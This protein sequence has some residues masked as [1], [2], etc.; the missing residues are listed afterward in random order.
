MKQKFREGVFHRCI[1]AIALVF[2][3]IKHISRKCLLRLSSLVYFFRAIGLESCNTLARALSTPWDASEPRKPVLQKS[4]G[5]AFSRC[6]IHLLPVSVF[7]FLLWINYWGYYIGT[8]FSYHSRSDNRYLALYQVAAKLQEVL[9]VASLTTVV[10]QVLRHDLLYGDGVPIGLLGSGISFSSISYF[11]SPE[12]IIAAKYCLSSW[13]RCRLYF[14]IIIAGLLAVTIGPASAIL[15]L[16]RS[17]TVTVGRTQYYLNGT[18]DDFW[19]STVTSI[20]EGAICSSLDATQYAVCPSGGYFSMRSNF[21]RF[22]Y[23]N[24]G[25]YDRNGGYSPKL[26]DAGGLPPPEIEILTQSPR[27]LLPAM[28]SDM[29]ESGTSP[30]TWVTQPH[31]AT[32][33]VQQWLDGEWYAAVSNFSTQ[34]AFS[35]LAN[36]NYA[37]HLVSTTSTTIPLVRVRCS[38]PAT[39]I[40]Q[41]TERIAFPWLNKDIEWVSGNRKVKISSLNR[42]A[43]PFL[44][45][46]W[47]PLPTE[48]FG[49]ISTGLLVELPSTGD[50]RVAFGCSISAVWTQGNLVSDSD[51]SQYAWVG[52]L[53]TDAKQELVTNLSAILLNAKQTNRLIMLEP[54][55]L[56]TL[57]PSAPDVAD[58]NSWSPTTLERIITDTRIT[59]IFDDY[60]TRPQP[61]YSVIDDQCRLAA[62]PENWTETDMWNDRTCGKGNKTPL[63]ETAIAVTVA[64]GLSRFASSR[65]YNIGP[66]IQDW[67]LQ[68]SVTMDVNRDAL[69]HG[70]QAVRL[71]P[72]SDHNYIIQ[73]MTLT[74]DGY[75]Y[76]ASDIF[77]YLSTAVVAVYILVAALHTLWILHHQVTLSSWDTVTELIAL[78]INSPPTR[79]L[80]NTSAGIQRYTTYTKR[81]KIQAVRL[82]NGTDE[83]RLCFLHSDDDLESQ[84][85]NCHE[86]PPTKGATMTLA[87]VTL[88]PPFIS[89]SQSTNADPTIKITQ[90]R[91]SNLDDPIY[92][93]VQIDKKYN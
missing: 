44:R 13:K 45:L 38:F 87:E 24:L 15:L 62:T 26:K 71:P 49:N 36:Y 74:I 58:N 89:A 31:A 43:S 30:E 35:S 4:F 68:A 83:R 78:F 51:Y 29:R 81:L 53:V 66:D 32:I 86:N 57:T 19:P 23:T 90:V 82:E 56:A 88:Y 76:V 63:I 28:I 46:Q 73:E 54:S 6:I 9:C 33:A 59:K 16:P 40:T 92:E 18:A 80:D 79:A 61:Y 75:A 20:N 70:K 25:Y 8:G 50:S 1:R 55:W 69:L 48:S 72:P 5:I 47:L 2:L 10:L 39:N 3:T 12:F 41:D 84:P 64:D 34:K 60:R 85:L 21:L 7:V 14:I 22:N 91:A 11:W 37:R 93:R 65:A 77:D 42:T 52:H 17:Q 67:T 27:A